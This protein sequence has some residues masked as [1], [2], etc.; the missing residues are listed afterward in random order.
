VRQCPWTVGG[1][2]DL[3]SDVKGRLGKIMVVGFVA[4]LGVHY[5]NR[6]IQPTGRA[7]GGSMPPLAILDEL[8]PSMRWTRWQTDMGVY[9]GSGWCLPSDFVRGPIG[10][11]VAVWV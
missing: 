10:E 4:V 8:V 5:P 3:P 2:G 1:P 11:I 6:L 7:I 9:A